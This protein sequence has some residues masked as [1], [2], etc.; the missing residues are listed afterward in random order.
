MSVVAQT[1]KGFVIVNENAGNVCLDGVRQAWRAGRETDSEDVIYLA[2]KGEE[3][4]AKVRQAIDQGF[5]LIVAAGGD[6]TVSAVANGLIGTQA[7]L[8]IIPLG[9]TNVLARELG[10]PLD[11]PACC[12][13]LSG[14]HQTLAI[15]A[16]KLGSTHYFTQIGIGVDAMMI[17]DT[18]IA[19]KKSLGILAYL[20]TAMTGLVSFQ[21]RRISISADGHKLRP[22]ALQVV[23]AN[24]GAIGSSGL[25][26]GPDVQVDDGK[27]DICVIT[28]TSLFHHLGVLLSILL[29]RHREETNIRYLTS[30]R[31]VAIGADRPLHVQGDG[32]VIG[33]TPIEVTLVSQALRVVVPATHRIINNH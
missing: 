23:L 25:R 1:S 22:R 18:T 11:L 28:A 14:P 10:V 20:W 12:A 29:G 30:Q 3:I 16:M 2:Q 32:E 7:K 19:R 4:L 9:T 8:G 33:M 6:G 27:I 17:R 15:D 26:W 24:C 5:D 21:S 31:C 13:L